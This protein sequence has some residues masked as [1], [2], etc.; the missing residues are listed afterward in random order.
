MDLFFQTHLSYTAFLAL[1]TA[2]ATF[3][4]NSEPS[5]RLAFAFGLGWIVWFVMSVILL[6]LLIWIPR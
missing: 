1:L 5:S 2:L 3:P 6:L 4:A